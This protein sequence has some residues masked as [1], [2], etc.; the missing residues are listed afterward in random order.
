MQE[1]LR[2][3]PNHKA[4][5]PDG[6]PGL[7]LKHMPQ[8]F[9]DVL[10]L[11]FQALA[12]TGITPPTWLQ[13]HTILLYKKGDPTLL[14]NYRPIT[15]ANAIYKLWTTCIVILATDYIESRKIL[16]PEQEGFRADRSCARAVT[17]LSLCV[18]DAHTSKKDIVLCYL[19]FKGAFPSTDHTQLVRTLEFLGLPRDFTTLVSNLYSGASTQFITSH[20]HTPHV[21]IGRGTLQ[22]DPLSPLLFDLMIEPLIRWL[23]AADKGYNITSCGLQ[24]AS[25]WYADDG[26]LVTNSVDDMM[27]LLSIVQQFSDWSGIKLNIDKCKVTAY[28]HSLQSISRKNGRDDALRA[29]LAHITLSGKPIGSLSQDEPLPGGYLG[30]SLT[31]SLSPA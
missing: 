2:R 13:S 26:T 6:V 4:A 20:G 3:T 21:G 10:L 5:G 23:N 11:L 30:T 8:A 25:K 12:E 14:D 22:G 9:H 19:D 31:A 16:S 28:I 18:E 17:H 7:V 1:A 27:S 29:R 15:L 24:L